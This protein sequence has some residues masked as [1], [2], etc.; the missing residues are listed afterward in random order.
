MILL[1]GDL[2]LDLF[3]LPLGSTVDGA[4]SFA[5]RQGGA[6]ANVAAALA[7]LGVPCRLLAG[8]G[9]DA[10]GRRLLRELQAVGVD[11]SGVL[12]CPGATGVVF[13][14]VDE[15]GE[16]S[17]AG[18][19]GGA[20]K[21][22][23][24]QAIEEALGDPLQGIRWFHTGSGVLEGGPLEEAG[25]W[26]VEEA[27]GRGVPVSVDLNIRRHK[28]SSRE[29]MGEAARWLGERSAVLRASEE[30][31]AALGLPA[32]L[33][34]LAS[35][36]PGAVAVLTRGARGA[37]AR[38]GGETLRQGAS[39]ARVLET[40]G[41]GDAFTAGLLSVVASRSGPGAWGEALRAASEAAARA[42][43]GCGATEGLR[44]GTR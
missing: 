28:W 19:S 40:T 26:L 4:S 37:E 32:E 39:P 15:A 25:R 33:D 11:T 27:R 24:R 23:S 36:G 35:L 22:L 21:A 17:F 13:L 2:L 43:E 8:V 14:Q 31:L 38:V 12:P 7:C 29:R 9:R 6:V 41:A 44:G 42:V 34:A 16:R 20:E 18:H 5:P 30:D 1:L 10:H 3:A